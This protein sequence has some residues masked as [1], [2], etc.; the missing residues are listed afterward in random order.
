MTA[1]PGKGR[2]EASLYARVTRQMKADVE[3]LAQR[4]GRK[5]PDWLR[6]L[7]QRELDLEAGKRGGRR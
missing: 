7:V 5:P 3:V 6:R 1:A 4:E 2:M